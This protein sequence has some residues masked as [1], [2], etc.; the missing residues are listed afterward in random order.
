MIATS[1]MGI[2]FVIV[3][4]IYTTIARL[5]V[6]IEQEKYLNQEL[7]Y[8]IQTIQN[9]VDTSSID[10]DAYDLGTLEA[11]MWRSNVLFLT[12]G[13]IKYSLQRI[14]E[15]QRSCSLVLDKDGKE[16]V[17]TQDNRAW[18]STLEFKLMP[19]MSDPAEREKYHDGFWMNIGAQSIHYNPA[20]RQF[21][22]STTLQTFFTM[23]R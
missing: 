13:K 20:Q 12:D 1:I 19:W 4:Q 21:N 14:C 5:T 15:W 6:R 10:R 3:F 9:I 17:L 7:I 22:V 2:L 16:L 11:D 8:A 18:I 23:R